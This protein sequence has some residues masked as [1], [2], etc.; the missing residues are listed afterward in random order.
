M[1]PSIV[2]A[3]DEA[4]A[5]MLDERV[6]PLALMRL[7]VHAQN[8]ERHDRV[9]R[10]LDV[11]LVIL[12]EHVTAARA[13]RTANVRADHLTDN[14]AEDHP[15]NG[16]GNFF[17]RVALGVG[18]HMRRATVDRVGVAGRYGAQPWTAKV[19]RVFHGTSLPLI[20]AYPSPEITKYTRTDLR[21]R[22]RK[23]WSGA[24]CGH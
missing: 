7:F 21:L 1:A 16:T 9:G 3:F 13:E 20:Y 12:R 6:P 5:V 11:L 15:A 24:R 19:S 23:V 17:A 18:L 8:L 10:N 4:T 22:Q 2:A 14:V